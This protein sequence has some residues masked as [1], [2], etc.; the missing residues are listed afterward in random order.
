MISIDPLSDI[1]AIL[2]ERVFLILID[3]I[4]E[5]YGD[6]SAPVKV[7]DYTNIINTSLGFSI[8]VDAADRIIN[9]L[10]LG[11]PAILTRDGSVDIVH[12]YKHTASNTIRLKYNDIDMDMDMYMTTVGVLA[13]ASAAVIFDGEFLYAETLGFY[14]GVF[15]AHIHKYTRPV[16]QESGIYSVSFVGK[17]SVETSNVE[18][19]NT[20]TSNTGYRHDGLDLIGGTFPAGDVPIGY[21]NNVYIGTNSVPLFSAE[22]INIGGVLSLQRTSIT[23]T[24]NINTF[25]RTKTTHVDL[26]RRGLGD[27]TI[28]GTVPRPYMAATSDAI[29]TLYY[30]ESFYI[31]EYN[32]SVDV[33]AGV[34]TS[35][36][37]PY[38]HEN[39]NNGVLS[40]QFNNGG[41]LLATTPF[42]DF[43]AIDV[44]SIAASTG[45]LFIWAGGN[46]A[47]S[48]VITTP[49]CYIY[50]LTFNRGVHNEIIS[51]TTP[52]LLHVLDMPASY[53]PLVAPANIFSTGTTIYGK[54]T[55]IISRG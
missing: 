18:I 14:S 23:A 47:V 10:G 8:F 20:D 51:I 44:L 28:V 29:I 53:V 30:P 41:G 6:G 19:F 7:R 17:Y 3:G 36:T 42:T 11:A 25:T 34:G 24:G 5:Y 26:I 27:G 31:S 33:G 50:A 2:S 43:Y 9:F 4:Y 54:L 48:G 39:Q 1:K 37:S 32:T 21:P 15:H 35:A 55:S 46:C 40:V 49:K 52:T 16:L 13:F 22:I 12:S 45:R 38:V